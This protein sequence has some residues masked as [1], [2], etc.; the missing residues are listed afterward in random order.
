MRVPYSL[1]PIGPF[2]IVID[3]TA[4]IIEILGDRNARDTFT[5]DNGDLAVRNPSHLL[6]FIYAATVDQQGSGDEM[7]VRNIVGLI[8]GEGILALD[9]AVA[10]GT[11]I[12]FCK[13]DAAQAQANLID[14]L[15][16]LEQRLEGGRRVLVS[17]IQR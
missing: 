4:N 7:T 16:K 12:I 6:D 11:K 15:D 1:V 17:V 2:R 14:A 3:A 13:A 8:D 9:V 10:P 5:A